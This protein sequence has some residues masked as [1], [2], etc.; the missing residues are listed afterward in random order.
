MRAVRA[1][2]GV[3]AENVAQIG[4]FLSQRGIV[5]LLSGIEAGVFQKQHRSGGERIARAKRGGTTAIS[6][7]CDGHAKG[8]LQR[9]N[10]HAQRQIGHMLPLGATEMGQQQ[11]GSARGKDIADRGRKAL[12]AGVVGDPTGIDGHV[13]IDAHHHVFAVHVEIVQ[14]APTHVPGPFLILMCRADVR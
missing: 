12:D 9:R 6:G 13:E 4:K 14:R 11:R 7:E 3:I 8:G 5:R 2:E 1:G 10:E